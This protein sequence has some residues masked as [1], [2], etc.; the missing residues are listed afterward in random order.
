MSQIACEP[1]LESLHAGSQVVVVGF[2]AE[3]IVSDTGL[4][5]IQ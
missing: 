3:E 1:Q 4:L 2:K 5:P